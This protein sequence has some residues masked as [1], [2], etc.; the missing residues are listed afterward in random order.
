MGWRWSF[1]QWQKRKADW[2]AERL[3]LYLLKGVTK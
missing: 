2:L 1:Q 3:E